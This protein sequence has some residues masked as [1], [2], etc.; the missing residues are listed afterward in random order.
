MKAEIDKF[1]NYYPS[2][3]KAI[4]ERGENYNKDL[5]V[6]KEAKE[7]LKFDIELPEE[8]DIVDCL[9]KVAD[10]SRGEE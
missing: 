9:A 3:L 5:E 7:K 1:V 8:V 10:L 2:M 6:L 4:K